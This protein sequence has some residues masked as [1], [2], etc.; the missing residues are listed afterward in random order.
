MYD[1]AHRSIYS[2]QARAATARF[3]GAT[4]VGLTATPKDFLKNIDTEKLAMN[5]PRKLEARLQ[6]DTYEFFG[7]PQGEA[8]YRYTI[9]DGVN[10]AE[11]PF[12]VA[13]K[14]YKMTTVLTQGALSPEGLEVSE[15]AGETFRMK[16]LEK[17]LFLKNRNELMMREF[18]DYAQQTPDGE[19]G[20]TIIFAVSQR[21]A[22]ELEKIL[23]RLKSEY[24]GQFAKT[25]TSQIPNA[26]HIAKEFKDE[27]NRRMRVA[28]SVDMLTTGFDCPE[29]L[30]IVLARPVFEPTLYQQ[31]KG[32]GTRLYVF[33]HQGRTYQKEHFTL[34]DF[35]GVAEYFQDHYDWDA[36]LQTPRSFEGKVRDD[37]EKKYTIDG[38]KTN[39][40]IE[41]RPPG[42]APIE[43]VA[44]DVP[45]KRDC[46]VVGP[47]GD[48]VDRHMY[49]SKWEQ[50]VQAMVR[51]NTDIEAMAR[52][53]DR[54]GELLAYL[55]EH[56][57]NKP[58][59]YFSENK[60]QEG[61]G[62]IAPIITFVRSALRLESLPSR[63]DQLREWRE[64]MIQK[65]GIGAGAKQGQKLMAQLLFE[66]M[67]VDERLRERVE[68]S[69]KE[70]NLVF[71]NE[72]PFNAYR[73]DEWI[74]SFG[75]Q[76]LRE[77]TQEIAESKLLK[78]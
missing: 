70:G 29:I 11:G 23:N 63:D 71:L 35:C 4:K 47:D 78:L 26:Q 20:K 31:I 46:V 62:V 30:N 67:T 2:P 21:H 53:E 76:D 15:A 32:R 43:S 19:I 58:Q 22:L 9:L 57:L 77:M 56:I 74:E 52:D 13:P 42:F 69:A 18:L 45:M 8:T 65:Y 10:D 25:I 54:S 44:E 6:R 72:S 16:D 40:P 64:G 7:C 3:Y 60:L 50:T 33:A 75:K 34:F 17:K 41:T 61:Y 49:Q 66:K 37:A 1:E 5:D 14:I 68:Q 36:A 38:E 59:E 55:E 28:V 51:E 48:E 24:G 12:L 27:E 73:P 39:E